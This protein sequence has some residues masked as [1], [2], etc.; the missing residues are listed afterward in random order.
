[1]HKETVHTYVYHCIV[2]TENRDQL[3]DHLG[4]GYKLW[5][6][7]EYCKTLSKLSMVQKT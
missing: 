2:I 5:D 6:T 3:K 4:N 7:M 1:M